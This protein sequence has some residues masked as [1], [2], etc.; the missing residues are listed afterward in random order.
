MML[1]VRI[2]GI[3][4]GIFTC[5]L[6]AAMFASSVPLP[7]E[8]EGVADQVLAMNFVWLI[9]FYTL[10]A[11][12]LLAREE[13]DLFFPARISLTLVILLV[14][15]GILFQIAGTE[16]ENLSSLLFDRNYRQLEIIESIISV[17]GSAGLVFAILV[18]GVTP[19]IFEEIF[20][21]YGIQSFFRK[22]YPFGI[23]VAV[24]SLVFAL[25][26][27]NPTGLASIFLISL[28]LGWVY[29]KT[30]KLVYPVILHFSVNMTVVVVYRLNIDVQGFRPEEGGAHIDP[31]LLAV[32]VL[33][34]AALLY[35]VQKSTKPFREKL[36]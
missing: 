29:E 4:A 33:S 16:L 25:I 5:Q 20:F 7:F 30:G 15:V 11:I 23:S 14:P 9:L 24:T 13:E 3:L 21:R 12:M 36:E 8:L 22:K 28:L 27:F 34:L 1:V 31:V 10:F 19:A 17:P 32:S 35:L 26:H 18:V 2:I 6:L